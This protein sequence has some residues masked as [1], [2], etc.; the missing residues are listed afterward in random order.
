MASSPAAVP[1][2]SLSGGAGCGCKLAAA[3]LLPIVR[4]LPAQDDPRLLVGTPTGDDAAVYRLTDDLALVHTIDFFTPLVDDPYDFGRVAAANALSDVYAMGGVPITA[5]NVVAFPLEQLGPDVLAAILRGGL[6]VVAQ[7]GASVVGGHSIKDDEPKY[8]LAVTGTVH[9]DRIVTNAGGQAGDVLVL[10][11]PLGVGA[12]VTAAKR[13]AAGAELV[14]AA[15]DVMV[16]LNARASEAA[17]AAGA[18]AMTD[19]TGFGLLGHLHNVARES[20]LAAEV[21]AA[22][23]PAID[24]VEALLRADGAVSG[25]SA[26]NAEY[27][28]TFSTV[29]AGVEPWRARL[30]TDA[31]TSGG[32]L[33][34]LPAARAA[35]VPGIVVGR[36]LDG[37]PGTITVR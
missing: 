9:P 32:L 26:R 36:L 8:G 15:V 16:E 37:T 20:G 13:G 30:I 4:T 27:A 17:L 19:V 1:L 29:G 14:A 12:I 21:D 34:A 31:T 3:D 25:G 11:K 2:T 22:A 18:H 28:A 6:D 33:V 35:E 23:V 24:G 10:T 7:A 5:M